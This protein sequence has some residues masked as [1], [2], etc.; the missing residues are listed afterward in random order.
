MK[1]IIFGLLLTILLPGCIKEDMED[2]AAYLYFS[3]LGDF[4]KEIFPQK[5]G[6]VNLYVYDQN[7]NLVKTITLNKSD[8]DKSQGTMLNLPGGDYHIVCWG[9]A[10]GETQINDNSS[11]NTGIVAAPAYFTKETIVSNDSIYIGSK[12][13]HIAG[14]ANTSDTVY[15]SSSHIKMLVRLIGL[16]GTTSPIEIQMGNLSPTVDFR[17]NFSTDKAIYYPTAVYNENTENYDARFNVLRFNDDNDVYINL[18]DK[19]TNETIYALKL[20]DFML[21]NH[22][23][24]NGINEAFIG[25]SF[26]FNGFNVTVK[27]WDEEEIIPGTNL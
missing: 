27:P 4:N 25:I 3:Y 17:K 5:I 24:V 12:D 19:E 11:L 15:F 23:S 20:K 21:E 8:L 9:N 2:C 6:K 7:E 10:Y 26:R 14:N 13:I 22:I 18:I 1:K 16:D